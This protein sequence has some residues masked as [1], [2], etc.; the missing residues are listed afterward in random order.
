[1]HPTSL[2]EWLPVYCAVSKVPAAERRTPPGGAAFGESE[3][4]ILGSNQ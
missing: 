4:A 3:W 2:H 1:M